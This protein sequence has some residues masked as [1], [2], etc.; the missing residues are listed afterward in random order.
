MGKITLDDGTII[1]RVS[2]NKYVVNHSE[3]GLS[4]PICFN[5][6]DEFV[7][8]ITGTHVLD[9][10]TIQRVIRKVFHS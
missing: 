10:N 5:N 9:M 6:M 7:Y 1:E 3:H 8:E 2:I 4:F